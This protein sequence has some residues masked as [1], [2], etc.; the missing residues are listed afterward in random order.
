MTA[1]AQTKPHV[2]ES[3]ATAA[4]KEPCQRLVLKCSSRSGQQQ[5][6]FSCGQDPGYV[7]DQQM[8]AD[9]SSLITDRTA[10]SCVTALGHG[11]GGVLLSDCTV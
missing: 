8:K 10:Q 2:T 9:Q 1:S 3:L 7:N 11:A 6:F 5:M 4:Y